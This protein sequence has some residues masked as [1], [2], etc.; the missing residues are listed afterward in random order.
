M[1]IIYAT[2]AC[3]WCGQV[4]KFLERNH[5]DYEKIM[6]DENLELWHKISKQVGST[7]VPVTMNGDRFVV[8]YNI[9]KLKE[10]I[11]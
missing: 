10:L 6:L 4:Q 7:N 5:I 2:Q 11:A 3:S 9:A 8:G 1:I